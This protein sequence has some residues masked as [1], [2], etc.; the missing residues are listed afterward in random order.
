MR[1]LL[2]HG[3]DVN[4]VDGHGNTALMIAAGRGDVQCISLL[5]KSGADP[6]VKNKRGKTA[7]DLAHDHLKVWRGIVKRPPRMVV[8]A[9]N[10]IGINLEGMKEHHQKAL[11]EAEEAVKLLREP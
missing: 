11:A 5:L 6:Q 8:K 4:V 3:A 9:L 2:E 7:L 10:K 1:V